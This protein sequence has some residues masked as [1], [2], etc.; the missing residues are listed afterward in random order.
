[1]EQM[2]Q[3]LPPG[4]P[5]ATYIVRPDPNFRGERGTG[6]KRDGRGRQ[7]RGRKE[8]GRGKPLD[9]LHSLPVKFRSYTTGS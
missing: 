4:M 9:L 7:E 1:M 5:K 2:E 3:L 8:R 6:K